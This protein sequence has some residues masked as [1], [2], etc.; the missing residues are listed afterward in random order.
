M[1]GKCHS[2]EVVMTTKTSFGQWLRQRRKTFD[3]SQED[4][5]RQVGCAAVTLYKIEADE[6]RPSKQI[7]ALL[8]EH[9][10]IPPHEHGAFIQFARAEVTETATPWGTP[11]HPPTNLLTQ[12]TPLIGRN[13]DIAA[14]HKRLIRTD[15]RLL[16]LTGPPG[17]GKTRLSLQVAAHMLDD[18]VDG[19]F[20]VAL[21]STTD[22]N[23]VPTVIANA[24][25]VPDVGPRTPLERLQA[26]LRVKELLLVL[27]NFEQILAAAPQIAEVLAV[28]PL[29]KM[30][31][32]SRSS[33]GLRQERQFPVS[34]LALPALTRRTDA[35]SVSCSA[36]GM[37]F[38]ERAQ[39]V[40]P[41]FSI[42]QENASTIA[43]ICARLDG[44]PLAIELISARVKVLPS[45]VLLERLQG[46]VL[47]QTGGLRD[48]EP[49]H[50]TLNAAIEWSYQLLSADEQTLFRRLGV[51]IGGWTLEAAEI[52]CRGDGGAGGGTLIQMNIFDGLASLLEKN[53]V[54]QDSRAEREPR[55]TMLE[56]I[57]EFA[58]E[59]LASG[60]ELDDLLQRHVDYF[61]GFAES[62]EPDQ[63]QWLNKLET[64]YEN[65]RGA[66]A[67]SE[68]GLRLA[69]ALGAFWLQ[70]S[71]LS[72][73]DAW[74][75]QALHRQN[76]PTLAVRDRALRAKALDWLGTFRAWQGNLDTAQP[77]HEESVVLFREL[78]DQPHLA[79]A[80]STYAMLFV[81]RGEHKRAA[82][83]LEE[84]LALSRELNHSFLIAQCLH[85]LG[86]LAYS[87]GDVERASALWKES[88]ELH[89]TEHNRW[90]IAI[91]L[92]SLAMVALSQGD[93][94]HA[95]VQ[96]VE[97]LTLL[98][99]L[100]EKWQTAHT[101]EVFACLAVSQGHLSQAAHIFGAAEVLRETLSAPMLLFI[102]HFNERSIATLRA[103]LDE[104]TFAALWA[105]GRAMTLDQAIACALS[106]GQRIKLKHREVEPFE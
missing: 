53:L 41:D 3:I 23:L 49:R 58:L 12:P 105:E 69:V 97:S 4:L 18:F 48:V 74:I 56:T 103:Q 95:A 38:L 2:A 82:T 36:A 43:A 60:G 55:F 16:T 75:T 70:R 73:G 22:T 81:M 28:C 5:A 19:V 14:L 11:F 100:G 96:L 84:A 89:R 44:L 42:T 62:N 47:L 25:G 37:L 83:L 21:A 40:K 20:F 99:G 67:R 87:Q 45:A 104:A 77:C 13:D 64:D 72:E 9:L 76:I 17:V 88:L 92:A 50:R 106:E 78:G 86:N 27:D 10:N 15:T 35:E 30:L 90:L 102:R 8:A 91:L 79:E 26:F 57:R 94:T 32:T 66:L 101:L 98:Q 54:K 93:D 6:R 59:R 33:L 24:L 52:V 61:T 46:R 1:I 39:A 63:V 7:A 85:F 29:L 68:T 51:F 31:I 71:H 65:L 34:C 80:L